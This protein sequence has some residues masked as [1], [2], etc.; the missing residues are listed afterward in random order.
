ML[1]YLE[2]DDDDD[3]DDDDG[4][5]IFYAFLTSPTHAARG[6]ALL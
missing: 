1:A 2:V 6:G 4:D 5:D 3:D